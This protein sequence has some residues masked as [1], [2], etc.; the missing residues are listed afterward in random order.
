MRVISSGGKGPGGARNAGWRAAT[1][2]LVW[3]IDSDCVAEPDALRLLLALLDA[4]EVAGAGGSYGNMCPESLLAC[5]IHEEIVERHRRMPR[6]VNYLATF[7]VVYRREALERVGGFDEGNFNGPGSPGAEDIELAFRLHEAGYRLRFDMRS[8]V[9]HF[10][11]TRLFRYLRSQRHHGYWRVRLYWEHH[12]RVTGD[13]Y[14]GLLD[15]SQPPLAVM[16]LAALPLLFWWS[17]AL[18][19]VAAMVVLMLAQLPMT[20]QLLRR[21]GGKGVWYVP[22][23]VVRAFWRGVGMTLAALEGMLGGARGGRQIPEEAAGNVERG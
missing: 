8:R 18:I 12:L 16:T 6:E 1:Q 20:A 14:S 10:H 13:S 17:F 11:P 9:G 4:P 3:F 21:Q 19:P 23:G 5:L 15:H 7:N 2:P 22:L